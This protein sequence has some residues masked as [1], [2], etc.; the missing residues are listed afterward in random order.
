MAA[1]WGT[2]RYG[3][4]FCSPRVCP[5]ALPT[6]QAMLVGRSGGTGRQQAGKTDACIA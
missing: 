6:G 1:R 4:K 5:L 2:L 3:A